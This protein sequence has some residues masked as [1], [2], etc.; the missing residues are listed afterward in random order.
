[1]EYELTIFRTGMMVLPEN[2]DEILAYIFK[3]GYF[4]VDSLSS[5]LYEN[6]AN[7]PLWNKRETQNVSEAQ[8]PNTS[9]EIQNEVLPRYEYDGGWRESKF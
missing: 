4:G 3:A 7:N 9:S 5:L 1:L 8:H 6:F 2:M